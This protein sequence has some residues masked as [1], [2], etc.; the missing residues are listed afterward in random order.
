MT[1]S[2]VLLCGVRCPQ[3]QDQCRNE[4]RKPRDD[5]IWRRAQQSRGA[6]IR[7]TYGQRKRSRRIECPVKE[8]RYP[9]APTSFI[10]PVVQN[11]M[12][13]ARPKVQIMYLTTCV[14][15]NSLLRITY[16]AL[17]FRS[18]FHTEA[19]VTTGSAGQ[20]A[21]GRGMVCPKRFF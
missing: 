13:Y 11:W 16:F 20:L 19:S 12:T 8:R 9:D 17:R 6:G 5:P 2:H 1:G 14:L 18:D 10:E 3:Q 15:L 21:R 4:D 7:Q